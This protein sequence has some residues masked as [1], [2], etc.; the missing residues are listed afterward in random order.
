[1]ASSFVRV[2]VWRGPPRA[3]TSSTMA[4]S[5]SLFPSPLV[6]V[7]D[8][9]TH[10]IWYIYIYIYIYCIISS[11]YVHTHQSTTHTPNTRTRTH[12]H[13]QCFPIKRGAACVFVCVCVCVFG[14]RGRIAC[15]ACARDGVKRCALT[16]SV[17]PHRVRVAH[18]R[19]CVVRIVCTT[20][21]K[22][23]RSCV[24]ASLEQEKSVRAER[25]R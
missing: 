16:R 10:T 18:A 13:I 11:H 22:R 24:C 17:L 8:T 4:L 23:Q 3:A 21:I 15:R 5:L 19:A 25:E 12:K 7:C 2:R 6:F 1:M 9:H 14:V 20:I